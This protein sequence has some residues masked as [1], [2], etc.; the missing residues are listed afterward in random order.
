MLTPCL[1]QNGTANR[2]ESLDHLWEFFAEPRVCTGFIVALEQTGVDGKGLEAF[3][4]A[5]VR[6]LDQAS[7]DPLNQAGPH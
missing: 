4:G 5:A 2:L 6:E 7:F 3:P 1:F